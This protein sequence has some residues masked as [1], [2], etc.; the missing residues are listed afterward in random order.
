MQQQAADSAEHDPYSALRYVDCR[1]FL[2]GYFIAVIGNQIQGT[3]VDWELYRRTGSAMALGWAGLVQALPV[4]LLSVPAGQ[5]ADMFSRRRILIFSQV[6]AASC[7]LLL[8]ILSFR[9]GSVHWM[10]GIL[11]LGAT[12]QAIGWPARSALL[13][14][15]VPSEHFSN[16]ATWNSMSYQTGTV[17]G[18]ALAGLILIRSTV[19]AYLLNCVF[20]ASFVI[21]LLRLTEQPIVKKAAATS[22]ETF[23]AGIQFVRK[24]RII[25]AIISL[26]LFAVLFGGATSLLPIFATDILHVGSVGFGWMRAAPAVGAVVMALVIAHLPP[27]KKAGRSLLLAVAAFGIATIV[28][29]ISKSFWLSVAMLFL[30]GA[31]DAISVVVR[32]TLVQVLTPDNMRGRVSAVSNIFIGASNELGGWES[33]LT[34]Q[35]F[36]PIISVVGGGIGTVLVV[37]ATALVWPEVGKFGSLKDAVP[38]APAGAQPAPGASA[39]EFAAQAI[40]EHE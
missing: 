29:G 1:R 25:L 12:F 38:L 22:W 30:T 6:G 23:S 35:Y 10:Y 15:T 24:T 26:D 34:A 5:L 28:F 31:F 36:G 39:A 8:A 17:L 27:M 7:S 3:A 18:P 13:A 4:M 40:D 11:C 20:A 14:S 2:I 32:H 19:T 37:I 9:L 21:I 33:G 16:A